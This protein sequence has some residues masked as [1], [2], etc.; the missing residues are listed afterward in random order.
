MRSVHQILS[1]AFG[2]RTHSVAPGQAP[3]THTLTDCRPYGTSGRLTST[4][5]E[6]LYLESDS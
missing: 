5:W 4:P 1:A 3:I 6:G 2:P